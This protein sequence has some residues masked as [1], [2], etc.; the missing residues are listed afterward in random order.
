MFS[1]LK[2]LALRKRSAIIGF[3][4]K[5]FRIISMIVVMILNFTLVY[6]Y[7]IGKFWTPFW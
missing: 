2:S 3:L 1:N 6:P 7:I 4:F 5:F